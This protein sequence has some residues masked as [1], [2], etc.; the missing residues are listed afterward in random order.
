[1]RILIDEPLAM[2]RSATT[3]YYQA[4][5]LGSVTSLTNAAGTAAQSYTYDSFGNIIATTGSLVNS[6]RYTGREWDAETSLYY[7]RARYYDATAGK[8]ISEDPS[9]FTA[10]IDFYAYVGNNSENLV[11]PQGLSQICCR[12]ANV[13]PAE[14][15]AKK[16][17]QPPPCHCFIR[18][19]DGTTLGGYFSYFPPGLLVKRQDDSH[20]KNAPQPDCKDLPGS[21][22]ETDARTKKAFDAY[23][24]YR[25]SYGF[26]PG[27]VGTSNAAA[28]EMLKDAG[29]DSALPA[30]AWGQKH[31][32]P[33][34][35][36]PKS[37]IKIF[38]NW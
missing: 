17:L 34:S 36:G 37:F 30:C 24:K 32:D 27:D 38:F 13:K 22:C 35:R 3:S 4:D 6:F 10:G 8:F 15:W 11:D 33:W 16:T 26:D 28:S 19:S 9:G 14:F 12:P 29:F 2:L 5:G 21:P 23:P 18:Q 1:M 7:Y 31:P 20:D 25:G